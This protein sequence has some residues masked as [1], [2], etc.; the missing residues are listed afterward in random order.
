MVAR[1]ETLSLPDADATAALGRRLAAVASPGDVFLLSGDIGAGK[2]HLARAF[3]QSLLAMG[4]RKEDVPSPTFTLVQV[5]ETA[6]GEVW[7]SDLY[8]LGDFGEIDELGLT[9]AFEDAITLVEWPDRLGPYAPPQ[10]L[11]IS[12]V[13][14]PSGAGRL[15]TISGDG[16]RWSAAF[17]RALAGNDD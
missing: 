5:Y 14:D 9:E 17:S 8:R 7:H 6:R 12:L 2:T 15:T 10:A 11:S 1:S 13:P 3:I 16:D 4:G